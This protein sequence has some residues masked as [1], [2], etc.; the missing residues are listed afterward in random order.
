MTLSIYAWLIVLGLVTICF[1]I[2]FR[3]RKKA[4]NLK[5]F[6]LINREMDT[7]SFTFTFLATNISAA[8]VYLALSEQGYLKGLS[9]IWLVIAWIAGVFFFR[10]YVPRFSPFF[11]RV[12]TL[13]QFLGEIYNS[14]NV[15][16]VAS[17]ITIIAFCGTVAI[18]LFAV[19]RLLESIKTPGIE[20]GATK[21]SFIVLLAATIV[22][23]TILSGYLGAVKTDK[24]QM[25]FIIPGFVLILVV[26]IFKISTPSWNSFLNANREFVFSVFTVPPYLIVAAWIL[27]FPFQFA[28]LDMWQR[29]VAV[30]GD[31]KKIR[32]GLSI[33]SFLYLPFWGI[34]IFVGIVMRSIYPTIADTSNAGGQFLNLLPIS[35]LSIG[36]V[37][38]GLIAAI[39]STADTLL[40]GATYTFL[41]DIYAVREKVDLDKLS[42]NDERNILLT[43]KVWIGIFG[44]LSALIA[45][46]WV[47]NLY[48]MIVA[49]FTTQIIL[50]IPMIFGIHSLKRKA[51]QNG[52][53]AFLSL[54]IGVGLAL[55]LAISG[56]LIKSAEG[57]ELVNAAP[58]VGFLGAGLSFMVVLLLMKLLKK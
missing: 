23:Y 12:R 10:K 40:V 13:P 3:Y 29:C 41:Y 38:G 22:V 44:L 6:F 31:E 34:P 45:L 27:M 47:G 35:T 58:I 14:N 46:L 37:L 26:C 15:R 55:L 32:K 51:L 36:L 20:I 18:E 30:R 52:Q 42:T 4:S 16:F 24:V 9:S 50:F 49:I 11:E 53:A 54:L 56:T 19:A 1:V 21:V 43:S 8:T 2:G 28:A 25:F 33:S 57:S 48:Q 39:I 7:S 5:W 17:I